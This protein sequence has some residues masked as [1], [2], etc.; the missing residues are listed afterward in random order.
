MP[1]IQSGIFDVLRRESYE[2]KGGVLYHPQLLKA[3]HINQLSHN[4]VALFAN[5][6]WNL[7]TVRTINEGSIRIGYSYDEVS[8]WNE[9]QNIKPISE[10]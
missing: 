9:K 4:A 1:D 7:N 8:N 5:R 3:T 6:F 10:P 2:I